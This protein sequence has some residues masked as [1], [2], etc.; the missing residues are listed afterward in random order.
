MSEEDKRAGL[1][2]RVIA[3]ALDFVVIAAAV[4]VMPKAGFFAGLLY[5]L[6]GDGLF[7]GRSLGKRLVGLRVVSADI[8]K[9][10]TFRG[11]I[12]RNCTFGLGYL[13]FK[14][15]WIGWIFIIIVSALEF[16]VLLGSK[17]GMR[18]GDDIAKT[19]VIAL[20]TETETVTGRMNA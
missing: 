14:I 1:L 6:I 15:P 10:C 17:D 11:S 16:I 3:K 5:L 8:D 7:E 18:I 12:L 19:K 13:L 9:P 20:N 4:E 2:L